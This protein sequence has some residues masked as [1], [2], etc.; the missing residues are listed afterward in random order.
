MRLEAVQDVLCNTFN[1]SVV[2]LAK[3]LLINPPLLLHSLFEARE[4]SLLFKGIHQVKSNSRSCVFVRNVYLLDRSIVTIWTFLTY[5]GWSHGHYRRLKLISSCLFI[6]LKFRWVYS[7]FSSIASWSIPSIQISGNC[8]IKIVYRRFGGL[9]IFSKRFILSPDP[10]IGVKKLWVTSL[11]KR[12][13][14]I[15][16]EFTLKWLF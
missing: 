13:K 1:I 14:S 4:S 12:C 15:V 3:F 7:H 5:V 11:A 6:D 9:R 10:S 2:I 8:W 16:L